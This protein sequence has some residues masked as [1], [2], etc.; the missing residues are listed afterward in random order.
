MRRGRAAALALLLALAA[1]AAP[2]PAARPRL[3]LFVSVDQMRSD[4]LDRFAA[5]YK[6]GLRRLRERSAFFVNARYRHANNETGP[7]HATLLT[8]RDPRSSGI[9]QN[10]WYDP[11]LRRLVNVVEDPSQQPV[12]GKGVSASPAHL[13]GF[14]IGDWLKSKS[15]GT[16]VVSVALKDR[17]AILMGGRRADAAF[18]LDNAEGRFVTSTY[19]MKTAPAW[20]TAWNDQHPFDQLKGKPWTRLLPQEDVYR[21]LAGEDAMPGEPADRN[22]FPHAV[23]GEPG[24]PTYYED[25]RRLPFADELTLDVA[26]RA[27]DAYELGRGPATDV[28]IVGLAATDSIGHT[29]GPDSHEQMDNL[30]RLDLTLGRL[31]DALDTRLGPEAWLFG[32]SADHGVMPLVERLQRE[33]KPSRRATPEEIRTAVDKALLARF[34]GAADLIA[35]QDKADF[36]LDLE[37]VERRGLRRSAVE[38]AISAG[39]M[40]TGLVEHVYTHAELSGDTPADDPAFELHRRAFFPPRSPQLAAR[41][42]PYIYVSSRPSGTG[43]GTHHGYD[44]HVPVVFMGPGIKPGR[45]EAESGPEDIAP[46]LGALLGLDFPLQDAKRVLSEMFV[47]DGASAGE[48]PR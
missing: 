12:G 29:W 6:G 10:D 18:W 1:A 48:T 9:I 20:L 45:Y 11:T 24:Q 14:T 31:F 22:T 21:R 44:R 42:K 27:F 46:T 47:R 19:Y 35:V 8:G 23:R 5:L 37:A 39:L 17:S 38:A 13:Q 41:M 34:P 4:Y 30:L 25:T 15:P 3:L 33:G 36:Y 26:L 40:A 16:R 32:M 2:Q 7:G 28:F 43:H